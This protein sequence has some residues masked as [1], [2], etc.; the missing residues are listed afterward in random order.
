MKTLMLFALFAMTLSAADITG[1][2]NAVGKDTKQTFKRTFVFKQDGTKLT[3]KTTS[4]QWG[5][6]KIENGK[7]DGDDLSFTITLVFDVGDLK[8]SFTGKVEGDLIRMTAEANGKTLDFTAQ[9]AP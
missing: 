9:R 2:W 3:G 8:A 5:T 4:K 7:I 1:T 6:S